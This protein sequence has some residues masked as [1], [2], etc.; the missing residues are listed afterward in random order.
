[1]ERRK[2]KRTP[3]SASQRVQDLFGSFGIEFEQ[4]R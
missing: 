1:M 2:K 4:S 3:S